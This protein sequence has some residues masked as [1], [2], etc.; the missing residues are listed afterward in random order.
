MRVRILAVLALLVCPLAMIGQ[1]S[2]P[3]VGAEQSGA[4]ERP[5]EPVTAAQAVRRRTAAA[6]GDLQLVVALFRH[7]IRAP[8][9]EFGKNAKD[10]SKDAWPDLVNDWHVDPDGWGDLT[11]LGIK[12]AIELAASASVSAFSPGSGYTALAGVGV[13]GPALF[14]EYQIVA[15]TGGYVRGR[16]HNCLQR[17]V[18]GSACDLQGGPGHRHEDGIGQHVPGSTITYT[19]VITNHLGFTQQDNP[20]NEFVDVL[21]AGL[22]LVSRWSRRMRAPA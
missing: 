15:A 7:G 14:A 18:E 3:P 16:W 11:P 9:S 2:A 6:D 20:G 22:T 17:R 13:S 19:V 5:I 21:P 12:A 8:L 10:H 1:S 4:A